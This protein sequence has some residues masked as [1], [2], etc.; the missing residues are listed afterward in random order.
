MHERTGAHRLTWFLAGV[1]AMY[2]GDPDRGAR[3]RAMLKDQARGVLNEVED[4]AGKAARDVRNRGRGIAHGELP[5]RRERETPTQQLLYGLGGAFLT[6]WGLGRGGVLGWPAALGGLALVA[7]VTTPR[8]AGH[9]ELEGERL[10]RVQKT[11]TIGAPIDEVFEFWSRFENFPRF[12][13]H[14]VAVEAREGGKTHWKVTGPALLPIEWDA[15]TTEVI[16]NRKIAWR[17]VEGSAVRHEGDVRFEQVAG[18]TRIHVRMGYLPPGGAIGH[19]AA[20]FLGGDPK[21]LMDDDLLRLKSLLETGKATAK[22]K[23]TTRSD[24]H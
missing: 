22:G 18:G 21:H 4:V 19:V 3:R 2:L 14:V 11:L 5:H 9:E 15:V 24:V 12:M 16:P 6:M 23:E 20:A 7:R 10:I 13:E 17:S 1:G 8:I